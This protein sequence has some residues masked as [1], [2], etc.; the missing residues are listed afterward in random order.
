M[1]I[2]VTDGYTLNPGDL[3]W[4]LLETLGEVRY[5]DRTTPDEVISRCR[6]A[7]VI[8]TNKTPVT[9]EVMAAAPKLRLIAV[10]ATGY[11]IIDVE[12][13]KRRGIVVSNVPEYGTFS[14]AQHTFALLLELTNQAGLHSR[15]VREGEWVKSIDWCYSR[16]PLIE[17]KDKVLGIVGLGRIGLQV[18][19]MAQAFGMNVIYHRGGSAAPDLRAVSLEDLFR[20]SDVISLHCPLRADNREFVNAALLSL[21][22]PTAFLINTSRGPLIHEQNLSDAL[23]NGVLGGAALDVLSLEPPKENNP[24]LSAPNCIIT[25]HNAWVSVEAR[26]RILQTTVENVKAFLAGKPINVVSG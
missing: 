26:G 2:V 9:E 16:A 7:N 4:A 23:R 12:A 10:T 8:V 22:K 19:K 17:L 13:T 18:A 25:P 1:K 3:S 24:L 6:E 11:N 14:V 20:K 15:S 21:M 5:H